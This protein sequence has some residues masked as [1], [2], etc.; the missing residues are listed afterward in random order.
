MKKAIIFIVICVICVMA[1]VCNRDAMVDGLTE[2]I[3]NEGF[4]KAFGTNDYEE[5][6][7]NKVMSEKEEVLDVA[8]SEDEN[9]NHIAIIYLENNDVIIREFDSNWNC[10]G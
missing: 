1:I 8:F 3:C 6:I 7:R 2:Y 4:E 10:I 9:G 5:I